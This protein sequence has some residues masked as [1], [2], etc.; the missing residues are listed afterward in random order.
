MADCRCRFTRETME[1]LSHENL[2]LWCKINISD[3]VNFRSTNLRSVFSLAFSRS[4]ARALS[5]PLCL[6]HSRSIPFPWCEWK[7]HRWILTPEDWNLREIR[8][9]KPFDP[10]ELL[11]KSICLTLPTLYRKQNT[12]IGESSYMNRLNWWIE[13]CDESIPVSHPFHVAVG[14]EL[15]IEFELESS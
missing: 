1:W 9:H 12:Y 10:N 7:Q 8:S 15:R 13:D 5:L 4:L 11:P 6:S 3:G 14:K 2:K